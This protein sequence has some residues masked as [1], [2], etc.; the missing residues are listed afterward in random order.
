MPEFRFRRKK[1]Q[2]ERRR[3]TLHDTEETKTDVE[4]ALAQT[5]RGEVREGG[6]ERGRERERGSKGVREQGTEGGRE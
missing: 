5:E 2:E 1:Q 6:R 4:A 3:H